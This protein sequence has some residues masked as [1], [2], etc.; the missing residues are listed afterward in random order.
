ME[1]VIRARCV[2][3]RGYVP[4]PPEGVDYGVNGLGSPYVVYRCPKGH[5]V[6]G[7]IRRQ[8]GRDLPPPPGAAEAET[9]AQCYAEGVREGRALGQRRLDDVARIME[10]LGLVADFRLGLGISKKTFKRMVDRAKARRES[11]AGT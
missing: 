11:N 10:A 2:G 1:A 8:T 3:C 6:R 9:R 4:P 5:E 7:F